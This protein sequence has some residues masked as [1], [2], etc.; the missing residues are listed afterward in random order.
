[1]K[2][3][4]QTGGADRI[5]GVAARKTDFPRVIGAA[6]RPLDNH[7]IGKGEHSIQGTDRI[8]DPDPHLWEQGLDVI[9]RDKRVLQLIQA[10][11][12]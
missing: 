8:D 2:L 6:A 9:A 10:H 4:L 12:A 5:H 3:F 1:M 7:P 11:S